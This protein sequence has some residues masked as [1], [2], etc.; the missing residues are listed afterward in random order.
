MD[1]LRQYLHRQD[2][3]GALR[4]VTGEVRLFHRRGV[5]DLAY[6]LEEKPQLLRGA[7]V[8]DKIVGRGAAFLFVKGGVREVYAEVLSRDALSILQEAGIATDYALLTPY[9]IN[10]AG[11][12]L[13]PVEK[14]TAAVATADEAYAL[15]K[16][17][18]EEKQHRP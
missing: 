11:N 15:I 8:A 13:C 2:S 16:R 6:L 3:R 14:L 9:I 10:H 1:K 17:F 18:I 7:I 12:D 5:A 4:S